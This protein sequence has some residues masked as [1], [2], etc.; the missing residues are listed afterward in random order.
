M[1]KE[2]R[3]IAIFGGA[4]DPPHNVHIDI[5][6][7]ALEEFGY[8]RIYFLPSGNPPHKNPAAPTAQRLDMLRLAIASEPKFAIST[9]EID[10]NTIG[11]TAETLPKLRIIYG[12]FDFIIGGDSLRDMRK[13]YK[14]EKIL[15]ENSIVVA[16]RDGDIESAKSTL[17]SFDGDIVKSVKFMNYVPR[18]LSSTNIRLAAQLGEDVGIFVPQGV[19][20]YIQDKGVYDR[21]AFYRKKLKSDL[22]DNRYTHT[23]G[24]VKSAIRLNEQYGLDYDKVFL[25]ALLHDC[26]KC[27]NLD[28][29]SD[30]IP[31]DSVGTL[32]A[33]A[34]A[35]AVVAANEYGIKDKDILD[36]I[37]YHT[38]GCKNMS[39]LQKLIFTADMIE[40]G[41]DFEG[42]EELRAIAYENIDEGFKA[43]L[44][45][46]YE[47]LIITKTPI[48]TLTT[49]AYEFYCK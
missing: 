25:S 32:V 15:K 6:L 4:F 31:A 44:A 27:M 35:G 19:N 14:P 38:T 41:R 10:K 46:Q 30:S 5:A 39:K 17:N 22:N 3:K 43:C 49:Q 42:V 29:L 34:F 1:I 16:V 37:Y 9:Y 7:S 24:V 48:Y 20:E 33:H 2:S 47:F 40:D 18:S 36:A 12:D 21:Y 13:W 8:D 23:L 28:F 45:H 11:Y 26:A